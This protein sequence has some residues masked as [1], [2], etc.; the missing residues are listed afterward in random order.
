MK[1]KILVVIDMQNDFISGSLGTDEAKLVVQN[2][3][4]KIKNHTGVIIV[5]KDTHDNNYL[6]TQEGFHLPVPH[7][8]KGTPGWELDSEIEEALKEHSKHVI[9]KP[10]FGSLQLLD[11][12]DDLIRQGNSI[13]EIELVGLCTDICVISNALILKARLPEAEFVVD[14]SCCAGVTP[15]SH[16]NALETMKMCQIKITNE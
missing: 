12:V 8:I 6:N 3:V 1:T 2:V 4:Q 5:T 11:I 9:E 13:D 10:S 14:A 15:E 16:K 7:C